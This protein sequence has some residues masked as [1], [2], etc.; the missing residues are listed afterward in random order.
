MLPYLRVHPSLFTSLQLRIQ[1]L[2][3]QDSLQELRVKVAIQNSRTARLYNPLLDA[4][5]KALGLK[6]MEHAA[7]YGLDS[8]EQPGAA[9]AAEGLAAAAA[10]PGAEG[11]AAME[12]E[13]AGAGGAPGAAEEAACEGLLT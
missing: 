11:L 13:A 4:R 6:L 12:V 5:I 2:A 10:A 3:L 7:K 9:V 1:G 8:P